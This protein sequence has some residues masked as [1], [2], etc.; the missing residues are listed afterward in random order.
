MADG[1]FPLVDLRDEGL[2]A[3]VI[4]LARVALGGFFE[5]M[6]E[7]L[8]GVHNGL[9]ALVDFGLLSGRLGLHLMGLHLLVGG[10]E[11]GRLLSADLVSGRG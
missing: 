5:E 2:E 4:H 9:S 8:E 10:V 7:V 3:R 1:A 6:V 11:L